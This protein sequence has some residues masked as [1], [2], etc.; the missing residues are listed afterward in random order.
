MRPSTQLIWITGQVEPL[1]EIASSIHAALA[2]HSS[3]PW[4]AKWPPRAVYRSRLDASSRMKKRSAVS[5]P[6]TAALKTTAAFP[7]AGIGMRKRGWSSNVAARSSGVRK[8]RSGCCTALMK[9][10]AFG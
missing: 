7:E 6:E 3:R 9:S 8:D 4:V 1:T 10:S 5:V 2:T